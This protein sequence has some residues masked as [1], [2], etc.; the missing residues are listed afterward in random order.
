MSNGY[1]NVKMETDR[2]YN[3]DVLQGLK[4]LPDNSIDLIVTSPPYNKGFYNKHK[5]RSKWD[6]HY[7]K[8]RVIDYGVYDDNMPPEE[9]EQWQRDV[10]AEC[11]RVIKPTGSIF[12]NH[13]D[14]PYELNC[15]HPKWVYDYPLKEVIVWDRKGTLQVSNSYFFPIT[16]YIFWLKKN[17]E[18][19]PYF[20]RNKAVFKK[21]VWRFN[22]ETN[23][24]H[25]APF[26]IELP[27][28]CILS[29]TKE[30]DVVLDPFMGSGTTA[31]AA[32]KH[33]R[34]YI[35]FELNKDYIDMAESRLNA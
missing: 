8:S 33:G 23:N 11:C 24:S 18:A 34:H 25:P 16:E 4:S 7:T 31:L 9:Y 2:I 10:L 6:M 22:L 20:D 30:G 29:C 27:E 13:K 19:R 15:I 3:V 21:N 26:P 28:N 12:Y 35:G 1:V 5:K 17:R 14:T 32:K